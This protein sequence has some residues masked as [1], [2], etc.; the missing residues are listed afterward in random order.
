MNAPSPVA[1]DRILAANEDAAS[2]FRAQLVGKPGDEPRA[3]LADRGFSSLLGNTIWS[4]G[5]APAGWT[6]LR[7]HLRSLGYSDPT[8]EQAGLVSRTR[9]HTLIDRFRDR[10]TFGIRD[11]DG[12][13]VG[14][15][16]RS[17]PNCAPNVPKYLN[18]ASTPI[19]SKGSAPFG[20]GEQAERLRRHADLIITEGPLDAVAMDQATPGD[21][22][23]PIALCGTAVTSGLSTVVAKHASAHTLICFDD[24]EAGMRALESAYSVLRPVARELYAVRLPQGSD[25]ADLLKEHAGRHLALA[26]ARPILLADLIVDSRIEDWP[27][28]EDNL[29][30]RILCLRSTARAV[31]SMPPAEATREAGRLPGLLG[32][33]QATVTRELAE[34]VAPR[35]NHAPTESGRRRSARHPGA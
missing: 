15:T 7:D 32:V 10:V 21:R 35:G 25:P 27:D 13:L 23:A 4:V 6:N 11:I 24:D 3:Y 16:A 12:S 22:F 31:A 34:A 14:F 19:F 20:L 29:E 28:L 33:D 26:V 5:Y 18:T 17:A 30:A 9:H 8:L 1:R 2:Y